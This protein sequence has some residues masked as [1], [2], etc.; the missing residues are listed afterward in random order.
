MTISDNGLSLIK[1]FEGCILKVYLDP[2]GI[3]TA[4]VGHTGAD[5]NAMAVG[6]VISQAQADAWLRSDVKK[7]E[8]NVSSFDGT[9]HWNQNQY[10]ALVS[11]AFN[12]GS[13]NQ[14]VAKGTRTIEQISEKILAYNKASGKALA[15]LTRRRKAEKKLFDTVPSDLN[16]V[17]KTQNTVSKNTDTVSVGGYAQGKTYALTVNLYVRD[18]ANGNKKKLTALTAD[19]K[20]HAYSDGAGNAILRNGT[21]VTAKAVKAVGNDVWLQIPSGWICAKTG[22]KVYIK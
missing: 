17:S 2:V 7:A 16:E 8:K 20:K 22:G 11:F 5:V 4:G 13:I 9:Y 3:K 14:L 19:G 21:K 6:T 12:C 10:D 15:G 1:Q 18:A